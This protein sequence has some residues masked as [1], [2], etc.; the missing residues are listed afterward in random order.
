MNW[1]PGSVVGNLTMTEW[2]KKGFGAVA[3]KS[4]KKGDKWF[5]EAEHSSP[6]EG[7]TIWKG[8]ARDGWLK[9]VLIWTRKD[10]KEVS[11]RFMGKELK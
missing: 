2:G 6:T 11:F 5:F 8:E 9:G 1:P 7:K 4:E 3:F 10:G